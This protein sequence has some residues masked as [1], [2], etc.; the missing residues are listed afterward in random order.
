MKNLNDIFNVDT[1][2]GINS[3]LESARELLMDGDY[4]SAYEHLMNLLYDELSEL[5][6]YDGLPMNLYRFAKLVVLNKGTDNECKPIT[7][8]I[9]NNCLTFGDPKNFNDPMDPILKEWLNLRKKRTHSSI[10]KKLFTILSDCTNNL[11]ICCLSKNDSKRDDI[12]LNPLMWSHYADS[13]KGICIQYEITK[14]TLAAYNS[15][16]Q[17]LKI[18]S[19]RY[20]NR[21]V[22]SNYITL[23]NALLAKGKCW[24]YEQEERLIYYCKNNSITTRQD[25]KQNNGYIS[26]DNF[27]ITAIY[28]GY[29][30]SPDDK[31]EIIEAVKGRNIVIYQVKFDKNDITKLKAIKI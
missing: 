19:V 14:D 13:H 7:N 4:G 16:E 22:M 1:S 26:L 2:K 8:D 10:D 3:Q 11:K 18:G 5:P 6:V 20:R 21:K 9:K 15:D 27:I 31:R 30:I 29:R 24:D 25:N 17:I 12:F 28:L 23:D